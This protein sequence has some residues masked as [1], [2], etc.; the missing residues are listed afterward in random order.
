MTSVINKIL[1]LIDSEKYTLI[2]N[3][4]DA[5]VTVRW[6]IT[7]QTPEL[8]QKFASSKQYIDSVR[9]KK[10]AASCSSTLT[11]HSL[12]AIATRVQQWCAWHSAWVYGIRT[13]PSFVGTLRFLAN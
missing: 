4:L 9:K 10:F 13:I 2:V 8:R 3:T 1:P 5:M 11:L 12:E 7:A 6:K